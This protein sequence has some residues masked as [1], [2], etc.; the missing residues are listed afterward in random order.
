MYYLSEQIADFLYVKHWS[1]RTETKQYYYLMPPGNNDNGNNLF[2]LIKHNNTIEYKFLIDSFLDTLFQLYGKTN[3][4][5]LNRFRK[6]N[7]NSDKKFLA[8][9]EWII[10]EF[11]SRG[12][13]IGLY[14]IYVPI[15]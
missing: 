3:S 8:K 5:I 2:K 11:K 10:P 7:A 15:V 4:R 13:K 9:N 12:T 14:D 6:E 1:L